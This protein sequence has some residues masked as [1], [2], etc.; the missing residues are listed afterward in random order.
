MKLTPEMENLVDE[1]VLEAMTRT[2]SGLVSTMRQLVAHGQTDKQ[3][4]SHACN[5]GATPEL[6]RNMAHCLDAIR[7]EQRASS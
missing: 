7:R 1:S 6:M 3:I 5:K 2:R 4:L